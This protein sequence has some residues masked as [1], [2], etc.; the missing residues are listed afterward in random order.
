MLHAKGRKKEH[1]NS[2]NE[3]KSVKLQFSHIN[4]NW[5]FE[6]FQ[7]FSYYILLVV[8]LDA[9]DWLFYKLPKSVKSAELREAR[10]ITKNLCERSQKIANGPFICMQPKIW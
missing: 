5:S 7:L 10:T 3:Y 6:D 8:C 9:I 2:K 4:E 1:G